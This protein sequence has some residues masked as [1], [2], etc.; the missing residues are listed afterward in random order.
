MKKMKRIISATA[1]AALL[2][3]ANTAFAYELPRAFWAMADRYATAQSSGNK[4]DLI[5]AGSDIVSLL[6]GEEKNEQ[7]NTIMGS[8]LYD[9]GY[10]YEELGGVE[11]Y[12]KAGQC[13]EK[14]IPYGNAMGW[15]DGV[16]IA[17][18]KSM[19]FAPQLKLYTPTNE[20]QK[21]FGAVNE[22]EKG[23]LYGEV[24]EHYRDSESMILLYLEYGETTDFTWTNH[25]MSKAREG[26]KA[27]ELALNFPGE[28]GQIDSIIADSGYLN[29]V[30]NI[31]D[32]YKDVP[33]FLRIG[34]EMNIW[35]NKADPELFKQA[36][37]KIS[38]A[39]KTGRQN[40]ATVWSVVHTS[41]WSANFDDYY[42]GD[43]YVDWVGVSAYA[44]KYFGAR[45]WPASESHNPIVYKAG[46][47]A[48]PVLMIKDIVDLYGDRKPIMLAECGSAYYT[49]GEINEYS[50][51]WAV[52]SLKRM[53]SMVPIVY[54]Q[55]KLI[56]YF[57]KNISYENNY[58]DLEGC[59]E[60]KNAYNTAVTYPWFIQNSAKNSVNN[61]YKL[62]DGTISAGNTLELYAYPHI[63]TVDV[64][65][66][67]Y[68]I[69]GTWVASS[70]E[71]PYYTTIDLSAYSAGE[72]TLRADAEGGGVSAISGT[73]TLNITKN[74]ADEL[75]ALSDYQ[76]KALEYC[77]SIGII[78]GYEDGTIRPYN[79]ITR[80]EFASLTARFRGLSSEEACT[81]D[82]ASSHWST[83]F[84]KACVDA[85][86]IS[87]MGDNKFAPD[88]NVTYEQ[89]VKILTSVCGFTNGRDLE[90]LGGY[91]DAY[92]SIGNEHKLMEGMDNTQVGTPL[93]RINAAVLFYNSAEK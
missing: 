67:N 92:L 1:A 62:A 6:E 48:D 15:S 21:Y 86:A 59:G 9:M 61:A 91:P 55:V 52:N 79:N 2:A 12:I 80:A 89:G 29:S 65:K 71:L 39:A 87:G 60:L 3:G 41:E 49:K 19:Q 84:I 43:E 34:A 28:G 75:A 57:N 68:Y 69:D 7:V 74:P 82:D 16:K 20:T 10:A 77:K 5:S 40:V 47:A 88:I 90:S 70:A 13:F 72:H 25:I 17:K 30:L 32:N 36:F 46:D 85:G 76:K 64:P 73:Y 83:K 33:V 78:S 23:V 81:F 31:L 14:Y 27:V 66:V 50:T 54:P 38:T 37:R 22:P 63:Y 93:N 4:Y 51:D 44:N 56:A 24:S 11:N 26:G 53:Y 45:T 35:Q 18:Q 58:Y 8:K 42:P